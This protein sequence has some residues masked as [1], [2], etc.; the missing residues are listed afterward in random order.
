MR[1]AM[2]CITSGIKGMQGFQNG[3]YFVKH[4]I[5]DIEFLTILCE[6]GIGPKK[7]GN[8]DGLT[9]TEKPDWDGT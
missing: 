6:I 1:L 2:I 8:I 9:K 7:L 3:F 5:S 4:L